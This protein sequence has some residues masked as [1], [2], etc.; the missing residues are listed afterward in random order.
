MIY[1]YI[2]FVCFFPKGYFGTGVYGPGLSR[3]ACQVFSMAACQ[4]QTI[5]KEMQSRRPKGTKARRGGGEEGKGTGE[6]GR[7]MCVSHD[8]KTWWPTLLG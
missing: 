3:C 4:K 7:S 5:T 6:R 2:L 1:I 8:K